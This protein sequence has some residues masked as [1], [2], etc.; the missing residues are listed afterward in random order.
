[1]SI[2][3]ISRIRFLIVMFMLNYN[4]HISMSI[5]PCLCM[6]TMPDMLCAYIFRRGF[7]PLVFMN[8]YYII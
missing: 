8:S 1:M 5:L 4:G 7:R 2:L 6:D 3:P